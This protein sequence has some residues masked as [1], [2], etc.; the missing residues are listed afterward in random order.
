MSSCN[1]SG[2]SVTRISASSRW[3]VPRPAKRVRSRCPAVVAPSGVPAITPPLNQLQ[4]DLPGIPFDTTRT[5]DP[6]SRADM[7]ALRPAAPLPSTKTSHERC[8]TPAS[9]HP[10]RILF[11]HRCRSISGRQSRTARIKVS[12]NESRSWRDHAGT[13]QEP[14]ER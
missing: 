8:S 4:V 7:A 3:F 10:Q 2:A 13:G 5:S 1:L 14:A 6:C 9:S 12:K 11:P